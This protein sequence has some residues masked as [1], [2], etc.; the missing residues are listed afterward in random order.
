M[1]TEK[2]RACV[3]KQ[4]YYFSYLLMFKDIVTK[5]K[6]R[7]TICSSSPNKC[8]DIRWFF[9]SLNH[10]TTTFKTILLSIYCRPGSILGNTLTNP[11][12]VAPAFW[13]LERRQGTI[14]CNKH[15]DDGVITE[16][17]TGAA[18]L[19]EGPFEEVKFRLGTRGKRDDET[20]SGTE[21]E[22]SEARK[23]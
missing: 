3:E 23:S 7:K 6:Y 18:T 20:V 10:L 14:T 15:C 1:K 17:T 8:C 4:S 22:S 2:I 21:C 19:Q 13:G 9:S 5:A 12:D 16:L 11:Q